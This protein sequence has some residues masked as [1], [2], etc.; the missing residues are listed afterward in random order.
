M[1]TSL[2][3]LALV[4]AATAQFGGFFDQMFGNQGHGGQQQQRQNVPSDP[5]AYQRGYDSSRCD[6]YLCPDTLGTAP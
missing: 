3:F 6:K 5:S 2:A 4:G 1:R